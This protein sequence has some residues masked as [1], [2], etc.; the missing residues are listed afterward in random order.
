MNSS[1]TRGLDWK[2]CMCGFAIK[3]KEI[4]GEIHGD[5]TDFEAHEVGSIDLQ[6]CGECWG[7]MNQF[8]NEDQGNAI[9]RR[10]ALEREK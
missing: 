1:V 6:F 8:L 10:K 3:R 7:K 2:C 5:Y 4:A 9:L